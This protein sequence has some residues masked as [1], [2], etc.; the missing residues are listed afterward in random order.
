[1]ARLHRR[2]GVSAALRCAALRR[3]RRLPNEV[4]V[5]SAA[6]L[7]LLCLV[8]ADQKR[9]DKD[10]QTPSTSQ[11]SASSNGNDLAAIACARN[12]P[13]HPQYTPAPQ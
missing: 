13:K 8:G 6:P 7:R 11:W 1:V 4:A 10:G 12:N 3:R 9:R 2:G 5:Q